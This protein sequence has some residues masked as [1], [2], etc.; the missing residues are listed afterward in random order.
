MSED[1]DVSGVLPLGRCGLALPEL[2]AIMKTESDGKQTIQA[3]SDK[4]LLHGM[5]DNLGV[6]QLPMLLALHG[7]SSRLQIEQEVGRYVQERL[8]DVGGSEVIM[9]PSHLSN[10][11][12]VLV[13]CPAPRHERPQLSAFLAEHIQQFMA[14][15]AG[16]HESQALQALTP[17][18]V[19]QPK[20]QSVVGF[21]APL[22]L[23]V[24]T[25]WG[26]ARL[27]IWWW[28][29]GL[30]AVDQAPHRNMWLVRVP[31]KRGSLTA[32]D[33]WEP[34]HEHQGENPGFDSA[35]ELFERHMPAMAATAEAI[36]VAFGA[37]FLRADFFVG[38]AEWG[39]RLNEVAY[40]C[41]VEYRCRG[42]NGRP[43]DD[44]PQIARILQEGMTRCQRRSPAR[45][46]LST[47]GVRGEDYATMTVSRIPWIFRQLGSRLPP[48]ALRGEADDE[49]E[50]NTV[51]DALCKT[52]RPA[53]HVAR[54]I[55][56]ASDQQSAVQAKAQE[57]SAVARINNIPRPLV[58]QRPPLVVVQLR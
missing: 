56:V 50:E 22:E 26:K 47:L 41:G 1:F 16:E 43:A 55:S 54:K 5:L 36:A 6:P 38:S 14:T 29:R 39:V 32:A 21:K 35:L 24:V 27:G 44:A 25:L 57:Q 33:A 28:G 3:L 31:A 58:P 19:A 18:F 11:M 12:G 37:P 30:E 46:F 51:P 8:S 53:S 7:Y 20:Y 15:R 49:A 40:G 45:R 42:A 17:G 4:V 52:M 13:V 10:G 48:D 34:V 9:K 23:R 2:M